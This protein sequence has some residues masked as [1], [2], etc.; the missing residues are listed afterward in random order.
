MANKSN[1]KESGELKQDLD[2]LLKKLKVEKQ[3]YKKVLKG[4]K[5][6]HFKTSQKSLKNNPK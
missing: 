4:L 2:E 1:S 5:D 6:N 3:I